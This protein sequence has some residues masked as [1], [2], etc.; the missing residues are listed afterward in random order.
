MKIYQ[1]EKRVVVED[2]KKI[3]DITKLRPSIKTSIDLIKV[4][5]SNDLTVSEYLKKTMDTTEGTFPKQMLF[6]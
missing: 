6:L 5:L 4:A 2:D 1:I 3:K